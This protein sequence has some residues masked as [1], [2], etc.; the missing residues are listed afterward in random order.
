MMAIGYFFVLPLN[1]MKHTLV[2]YSLCLC[3]NYMYVY[4][5]SS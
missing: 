2:I 5:K 4:F 1:I 3:C